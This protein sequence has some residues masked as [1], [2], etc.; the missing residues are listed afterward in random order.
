MRLLPLRASTAFKGHFKTLAL[1]LF[2]PLVFL[3]SASTANAVPIV[4]TGGTATTPIGLN[5]FNLNVTGLNFSFHGS[6]TSSGE[7]QLCGLCQPGGQFGGTFPVR[8]DTILA[9]T[10][11]GTVYNQGYTIISS[12]NFITLPLLTVPADFSPVVSPFT[13]VGLISVN[14]TDGSAPFTFEL[15]GAGTATFVFLP[16]NGGTTSLVQA[17]YAFA[18]PAEPVPEP[19]TL[20]LLGTGLAGIVA[21][22]RHRRRQS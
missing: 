7:T 10:Y 17:T 18:P 11:N 4:I 20:L 9:L 1:L 6:N 2:L 12:N 8:L 13:F 15:T 19:A 3:C 16:T 14:P 22:V 5:N 21:K